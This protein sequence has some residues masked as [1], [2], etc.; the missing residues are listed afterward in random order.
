MA[1]FDK[2]IAPFL[3]NLN[4]HINKLKFVLCLITSFD[5]KISDVKTYI[6]DT[7]CNTKRHFSKIVSFKTLITQYQ[8]ILPLRHM[9]NI[10]MESRQERKSSSNSC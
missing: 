9:K 2:R 3:Q 1:S 8:D 4:F 7:P 6:D 5:A 10:Y